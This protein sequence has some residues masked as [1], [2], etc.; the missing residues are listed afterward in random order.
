MPPQRAQQWAGHTVPAA[1]AALYVAQH[2]KK[3]LVAIV[4]NTE[5]GGTTIAP[6]GNV[7]F[8]GGTT[9]VVYFNQ[10]DER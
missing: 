10:L 1:G 2:G 8:T 4:Q 6:L 9:E 3:F 5:Y 7:C